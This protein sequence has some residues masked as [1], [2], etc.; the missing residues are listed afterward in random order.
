M[1]QYVYVLINASM[2]GLLKI[3]RTNRL[4][5][6]RA[7]ELSKATNMPTPFIVAYEED[8]PDSETAERLIHEEL[9]RQGFR[10]SN[11][12]EFFSAPLKD[13]IRIVSQVAQHLRETIPL[14]MP[15]TDESNINDE[16]LATDCLRRGLAALNGSDDTLQDDVAAREYFERAIAFGSV[17]AHRF[18]ALLYIC[19]KGVR[20]SPDIALKILK[21]G[22]DKGDA[23]CFKEMWDVYAGNTV[24]DVAHEAN[25]EVC[26]QWFLN[27]S[28]G[29]IEVN[30]L[31]DYLKHSYESLGGSVMTLGAAKYSLRQFPGKHVA[32]VLDIWIKRIRQFVREF[33]A[34]R[35]AGIRLE[36]VQ[37]SWTKNPDDPS[38]IDLVLFKMFLT[39]CVEDGDRLMRQAMEGV[40]RSDLEYLFSGAKDVQQVVN[41][42]FP[43][44]SVHPVVEQSQTIETEEQR[45]GFFGRLFSR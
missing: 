14:A 35:H 31:N 12:R 38:I 8:V 9:T 30:A 11:G 44:I 5:E 19:G 34:A 37:K 18:L 10:I 32:V 43:F 22:G 16:D 28:R 33:Q 27:S 13:A 7:A 36:D 15:C 6:E 41:E 26:F 39:K 21:A 3:G 25:A 40:V 17:L 20:Q 4:P 29:N 24:A 45:R 2:S 42:Y 1:S 23:Q